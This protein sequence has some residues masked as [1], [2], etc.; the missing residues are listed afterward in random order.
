M[1]LLFVIFLLFLMSFILGWRGVRYNFIWCLGIFF[2]DNLL[3]K[4]VWGL[5]L[6]RIIGIFFFFENKMGAFFFVFY[7]FRVIMVYELN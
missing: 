2:I 5:N 3:E 6:E 1:V 4:G 7:F